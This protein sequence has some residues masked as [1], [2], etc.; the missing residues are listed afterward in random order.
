MIPMGTRILSEEPIIRVL[1]AAPDTQ[2][3]RTSTVRYPK[4][5]KPEANA[6]VWSPGYTNTRNDRLS[7]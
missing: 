3:L 2:A 5:D 7:L 4:I 1:E 6:T